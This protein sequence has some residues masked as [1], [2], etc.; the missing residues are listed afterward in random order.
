MPS[1]FVD[2]SPGENRLSCRIL[3]ANRD[4]EMAEIISSEIRGE[5]DHVSLISDGPRLLQKIKTEDFQLLIMDFV[6]PELSGCAL[7]EQI[8]KIKSPDQLGILILSGE[9]SD[10]TLAEAIEK[11]AGDFLFKP[12]QRSQLISRVR[13]LR[14]RF[15]QGEEDQARQDG[16]YSFGKFRLNVHSSDF[17]QGDERTHLTPSE[18]KLLETLF[19][20]RGTVLTR[21]QLIQEVQGA[22]V[23]VI[24]RAIDT[25][26]FSLR[27]KLGEFS[28][29]I[30]TVRGIGYRIGSERNS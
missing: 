14:S 10:E 9:L 27:K 17:Y 30:E 18:F 6:L 24:D 7:I 11:G 16:H 29:L 21:D 4:L 23:V 12:Y 25:H 22:G 19:R 3:I 2:S 28:N 20:R 5:C 15:V 8:R 13:A 1:F 26:V